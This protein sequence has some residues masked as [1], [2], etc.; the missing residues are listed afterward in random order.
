[1]KVNHLHYAIPLQVHANAD[2]QPNSNPSEE[3]PFVIFYIVA[4]DGTKSD[5]QYI[6][7]KT[8]PQ[9]AGLYAWMYVI[10][11]VNA[12]FKTGSYVNKIKTTHKLCDGIF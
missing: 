7:T 12:E 4:P 11:D 8:E 6:D 5:I 9:A 10:R 1:M 2:A 3:I